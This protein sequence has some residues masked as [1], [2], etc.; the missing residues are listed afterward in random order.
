MFDPSWTSNQSL[1]QLP[2]PS[3]SISCNKHCTEQLMRTFHFS[4]SLPENCKCK[5]IQQF[6]NTHISEVRFLDRVPY[7]RKR[8]YTVEMNSHHIIRNGSEAEKCAGTT[9]LIT[10]EGVFPSHSFHVMLKPNLIL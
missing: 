8:Y 6:V 7:S 3:I 1:L 5:K 2:V 9:Q 4:A 10:P